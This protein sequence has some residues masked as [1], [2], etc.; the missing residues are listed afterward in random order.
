MQYHL[1]CPNELPGIERKLLVEI[2][3]SKN[4]I[5]PSHATSFTVITENRIA[6]PKEILGIIE[7][8]ANITQ[9]ELVDLV[10]HKLETEEKALNSSN[11]VLDTDR[12]FT[13]VRIL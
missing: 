5:H 9:E 13:N 11:N 10:D 3:R 4:E 2:E 8:N 6:L 12:I 1:E 7:D